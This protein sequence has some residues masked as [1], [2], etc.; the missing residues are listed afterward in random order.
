[1]AAGGKLTKRAV[2][3]FK[4]DPE[5]PAVQV[6]WDGELRGF[7][8]RVF[9]TG[10]KSYVLDYRIYGRKRRLTLGLH[11]EDLT[12]EQARTEAQKNRGKIAQGEDPLAERKARRQAAKA[13]RADLTVRQYAPVYIDSVRTIGNPGRKERKPKKTW[14]EDKRRIDKYIVPAFGAKRLTE[15][16]KGDVRRLHLK[17]GKAA[18][19]EANRVL[20]LVS[21]MFTS[22]VELGHLPEGHGNPAARITPFKEASRDRWVTHAE[23]PALLEA[24]RA[25]DDVHVRA[26]VVLALLLGCRKSELLTA[27]WDHVDLTRRELTLPET[28]AGNT[29]VVPLSDEAARIVAE[30]P[31]MLGNPHVFPSPVKP[32]CPMED[33]RTQ[34]DR[35]RA[36]MWMRL[37]PD[38][39]VALRT[40][41]HAEVERRPKRASKGP[42]AVEVRLIALALDAMKEDGSR[43]TFHDLRRTLGSWLATSGASLHLIGSVLNHAD[44][45]TTT[46]YARLA[47]GA[48]RT[49][50]EQHAKAVFTV[51]GA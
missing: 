12:P 28:K 40:R 23:M 24:I 29:H 32:G 38:E 35:V 36:G 33:I 42:K 1:M 39:A 11:G 6:L 48:R 22:A 2:D 44:T 34:W 7:G 19:V 15:V 26:L 50:L 31:R 45:E 30:L 8:V 17:I 4:H 16:D 37:H 21:V 46:I 27:R 10:T 51:V 14:S 5:G 13:Q 47:D 3:A 41:A 18:P 9:D 43:L 20:A 49:A 25:E